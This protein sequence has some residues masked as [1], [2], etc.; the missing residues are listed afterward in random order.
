LAAPLTC[1]TVPA[2]MSR[3]VSNPSSRGA[4]RS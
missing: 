2:S 4:S 3:D 1:E